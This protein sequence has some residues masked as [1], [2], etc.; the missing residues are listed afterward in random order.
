[1]FR[2]VI[3][4]LLLTPAFL[5][6]QHQAPARPFPYMQEMEQP[7]RELR[8]QIRDPTQNRSSIDLIRRIEREALR[9]KDTVPPMIE[10]LP[11]KQYDA[12]LLAYRKLMLKL[13]R[14]LLMVEE[15]LLEGDN[16]KARTAL[17][18][19]IETRRLGHQTFT[20]SGSID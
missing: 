12:R 5:V 1:M 7:F 20:K 2:V 4:L 3:L 6:G 8:T 19:V 17:A 15:H 9:A 13:I 10:G 18:S 16:V 14:E 11:P